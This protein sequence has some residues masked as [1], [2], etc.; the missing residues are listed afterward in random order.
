LAAV[1]GA[2]PAVALLVLLA[3]AGCGGSDEDAGGRSPAAEATRLT[4]KVYP[5]GSGSQFAQWELR[6]DPAGGSLPD[7]EA[8]CEKLADTTVDAFAPTPADAVCTEQYGGPQLARV[9]GT[10]RGTAVSGTF[11]RTNGCEIARW[12]ALAFLFPE[13]DGT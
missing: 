5:N 7:A 12:D 2:L 3:A 6:C 4:I 1:H 8:A 11:T 10:L 13:D 9:D